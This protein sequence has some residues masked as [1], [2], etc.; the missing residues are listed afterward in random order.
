MEVVSKE[1]KNNKKFGMFAGVFTPTVLTILGAIMYLRTGWVVGNAGFG[2]A[3][4]IILLAHVITV[5]TGLAVSS[6]VTN[7]RV[8]AGGA[9]AIISQSLGLEVGG[10]VGIPLFLAQGISIALYVL[11]FT[12]SWLRIFPMHPEALVAFLTFIAVFGIV[13][14]SAQF[15]SKTQFIILGIVGF[16]LF[17]VL[18]TSFPI[19]GN[20][21]LTETPVFWGGFRAANFWETFAVF[22]PAV[23]GIMVGISMSGSLRKPRKDIPVG[24][25]SAIGLTLFV[26]LALAYWL[27]RIATPEELINNTTLMVDKAFWDWAILA[28]M[29]GATFSSALGSLVAAPRVMQ[30]L[31]LHQIIPFSKFFSKE[32][33]DGEPRQA[34][35]FAGGVGFVALLIALA[36]GGLDAI[37][38]VITMFFLITYSMLNVVVLIEQTLDTVSFRPTFSVPRIVPFIGALSSTFVMFL[39]NPVFSLIAIILVL[40]LYAYLTRRHLASLDSDVRSGLFESMAEWAVKRT[41]QMQAARER[42]WK[43]VVLAPFRSA[44]TLSGS[45][46]FLKA[47]TYPKGTVR[48]LGIYTNGNKEALEGLDLLTKAFVDDGIYANATLLEEDDFVNGVRMTTQILR[49]TFFRPNILFL[50]LRPD[51]DLDEL[52]DLIDKTAAYQMGVALLARHHIIELGREQIIHVWVSNQGP[53]WEHDLHQSNLD[54]AILLAYQLA[55]NWDARIT[56]NMSVPDEET[57]EKASE[58]L[59][60]LISLARLPKETKFSVVALPFDE[61]LAQTPHADLTIFG[62]SREPN[63]KFVK[64]LSQEMK[65]SCIFIRGSGEESILA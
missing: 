41:R 22:F 20:M 17:S 53:D 37:A 9:F 47:L 34:M 27:S 24:T 51:S 23:T 2:G 14:V 10:S 45:Y 64:K 31:A 30:A 5:S 35:F 44:N 46:R 1:S 39:I 25:M 18:L 50:H 33:E 13:Y 56:L 21:G 59:A 8:G 60:Q 61:T 3:V 49:N 63:L 15:A 36:G 62:L 19:M 32:S 65:G 43:P 52:Q 12:E 54:L 6:V 57:K 11:A 38:G 48:A 55:Q 4:L 16:S 7:T 26:Y 28:G 29:L 42:T 58:F 40:A